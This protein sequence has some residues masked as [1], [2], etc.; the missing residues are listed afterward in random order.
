MMRASSELSGCADLLDLGCDLCG[1]TVPIFQNGLPSQDART[2]W[3]TRDDIDAL[4][5]RHRHQT[6]ERCLVTD[7]R[8]RSGEQR[9]IGI[10]LGKAQHQLG[11]L[12]LIRD[13]P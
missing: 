4:L 10:G 7:K 13:E 1:C 6:L 9:A 11:Q 2:V 12:K 3:A 5:F 8:V